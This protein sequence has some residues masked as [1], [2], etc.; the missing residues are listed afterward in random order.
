MFVPQWFGTCKGSSGT[1]NVNDSSELSAIYLQINC[2]S[3]HIF[4]KYYISIEEEQIL[5]KFYHSKIR[6]ICGALDYSLLVEYDAHYFLHRYFVK[7]G[8]LEFDVKHAM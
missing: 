8:L 2:K 6:D 7:Y 3:S 1:F 5:R 4:E